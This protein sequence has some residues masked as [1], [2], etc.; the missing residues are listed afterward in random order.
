LYVQFPG[1]A[2]MPLSQY[3]SWE[4]R[5]DLAGLVRLGPLAAD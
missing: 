5:G 1:V 2:A 4:S 3:S